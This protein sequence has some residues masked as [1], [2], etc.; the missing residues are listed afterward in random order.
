MDALTGALGLLTLQK[1]WMKDE[2]GD[3]APT[4]A[5]TWENALYMNPFSVQEDCPV[6]SPPPITGE[7]DAADWSAAII[8]LFA[9]YLVDQ[10]NTCA[11]SL[12]NC[13][14]CVVSLMTSLAPYGAGDAV[15][16]MLS[17]LCQDLN[18]LSPEERAAY[19]DDCVYLPLFN[20]LKDNIADNPYDWLNKLSDWLFAWLNQ[21]SDTILQDI[22]ITAAMLG[23]GGLGNWVNDHG[24]AGGGADFG[25]T[26]AWSH[27]LDFTVSAYGFAVTPESRSYCIPRVD[28]GE[29][30]SGVGFVGT[31]TH[32]NSCQLVDEQCF[33]LTEKTFHITRIDV[34][35]TWE[36]VS[37]ASSE[38]GASV[39]S[40]DLVRQTAVLGDNVATWTGNADI[41]FLFLFGAQGLSTTPPNITI[42]KIHVEGVGFDPWA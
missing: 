35:E 24:G 21:T 26:C 14:D 4:V 33:A 20:N 8:Q 36:Y 38:I 19:V 16:G 27:D 22:S 11:P 10:L 40:G 17:K 23:G 15:Q 37:G 13:P 31:Q 28:A 25:D 7:E 42:T 32:N 2:T 1:S 39:D 29:Y 9:E 6:F 41:T 3:G 5:H 34:Y 30:V 18:A 12:S